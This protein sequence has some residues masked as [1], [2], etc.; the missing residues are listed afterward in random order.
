ME[1]Q[2]SR[3]GTLPQDFKQKVN[4]LF[5]KVK[6]GL[7]TLGV[8][9]R[10]YM[11]KAIKDAEVRQTNTGNLIN[12]IDYYI[13]NKTNS[14]TVGV[15]SIPYLNIR[16][17]YWYIINYGGFTSVAARGETLYG[18]FG[19]GAGQN[20]VPPDASLAGTNEPGRGG[21]GA[22]RFYTG[23]PMYPMTPKN[24]I[25]PKN[26]IE[27]TANWGSTIWKVQFYNWTRSVK[28]STF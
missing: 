8:E 18:G 2:V 10:D 4:F 25:A 15:G 22:E 26:Y 23:G 1:I 24:P 12:A 7:E 21:G 16:A 20:L 28:I 9:T 5:I 14:F 11:R 27:K 19:R 13:E 3:Y 17:P 6:D